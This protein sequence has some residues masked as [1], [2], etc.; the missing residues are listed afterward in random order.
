ME[1]KPYYLFLILC[2]MPMALSFS[3]M[4][5]ECSTDSGDYVVYNDSGFYAENANKEMSIGTTLSSGE[6]TLFVENWYWSTSDFFYPIITIGTAVGTYINQVAFRNEDLY[7]YD[8]LTYTK[9]KDQPSGDT[10]NWSTTFNF[11]TDQHNGTINSAFEWTNWG[12]YVHTNNVDK[13]IL[14]LANPMVVSSTGWYIFAGSSCPASVTD[15]CTYGGSG[16]WNIDCSDNCTI[17]SATTVSGDIILNGEGHFQTQALIKTN[18]FAYP[19]SCQIQLKGG[20]LA[21]AG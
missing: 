3:Y 17:T 11:D 10:V 1:R 14:R 9:V 16:N 8:D 5:E 12:L 7:T 20:S 15:T 18:S 19:P 6:Y 21:I 4:G 13:I 2:I